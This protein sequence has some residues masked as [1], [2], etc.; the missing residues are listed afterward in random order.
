TVNVGGTLA[1]PQMSGQ[2]D[3]VDAGI[4][5]L[6]LPN[7]LSHINGTLVFAQDRIRIQKLTARTGGGELQVGGFLAYRNGLFFDLTA[8]GKDVRLRYPPGVSASADASLRYSG[9]AKSSQLSGDILVTRFGIN[10]R[11]DFGAYLEQSRK[12]PGLTTM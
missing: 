2:V 9:S 1:H 10:Q 4:S 6:D 7:G 12:A 3:L 5:F 8:T 11:F